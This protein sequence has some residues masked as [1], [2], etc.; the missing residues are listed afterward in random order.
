MTDDM[1]KLLELYEQKMLTSLNQLLD[2]SLI[3]HQILH[4]AK[5]VLSVSD[6]IKQKDKSDDQQ[7]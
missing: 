1:R 2:S 7:Q 3:L 5:P 4:D 6:S